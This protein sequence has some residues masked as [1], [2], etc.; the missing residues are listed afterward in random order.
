MDYDRGIATREPGSGNRVTEVRRPAGR[1]RIGH[2]NIIELGFNL[3]DEL[4]DL[5]VEQAFHTWRKQYDQG[6]VDFLC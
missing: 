4:V 3:A 2:M 5:R 6:S 1:E